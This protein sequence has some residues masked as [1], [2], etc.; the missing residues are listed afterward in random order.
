MKKVL[1]LIVV[2]LCLGL[3]SCENKTEKTDIDAVSGLGYDGHKKII[4]NFNK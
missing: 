4:E 2:I 1:I 3:I